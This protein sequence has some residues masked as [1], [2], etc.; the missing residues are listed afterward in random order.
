MKEKIF[1]KWSDT[2][3]TAVKT[4]LRKGANIELR[5]DMGRTPLSYAVEMGNVAVTRI[6]IEWGADV[7]SKDKE[8]GWTPLL[9]AIGQTNQVIARLLLE[10]GANPESSDNSGHTPLSLAIEYGD[11]NMISLVNSHLSSG[12]SLPHTRV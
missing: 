9:W 4:L 7:E 10:K 1:S 2:E 12:W 3:E 8:Q 11:A 5:D 6:L